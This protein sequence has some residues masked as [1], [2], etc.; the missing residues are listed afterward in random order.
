MSTEKGHLEACGEALDVVASE[1]A[2]RF[3]N[4]ASQLNGAQCAI[5][6]VRFDSGTYATVLV[7]LGPSL[8]AADASAVSARSAKRGAVH[9]MRGR[10]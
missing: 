1:T 5:L 4:L 10:Q 2:N 8:F 3:L 7:G 9:T 6:R